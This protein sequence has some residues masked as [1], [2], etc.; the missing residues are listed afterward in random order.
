MLRLKATAERLAETD[1][2]VVIGIGG[3]LHW[4]KRLRSRR[5]LTI[6][7][8]L[9]TPV[10]I[11][12]HGITSQGSANRLNK[13]VA[14][15]VE[16][17][18]RNYNGTSGCFRILKDNVPENVRKQTNSTTTDE[19][20]GALLNLAR[21]NGWETFVVPDDIGGRY[22]VLSAVGLLPIA[23]SGVDIDAF[24]KGA[25]ECAKLAAG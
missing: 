8:R 20:K 25:V 14:I 23:Y 22:S 12:L 16:T 3:D 9:Y 10:R 4:R 13:K 18:V 11:Y 21:A 19:K 7:I 17:Q 15:N 5:W 6:R 24:V 2:L 1:V